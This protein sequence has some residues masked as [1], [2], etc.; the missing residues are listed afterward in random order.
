M[1]RKVDGTALYMEN[2]KFSAFKVIYTYFKDGTL[3]RH[4]HE[5][6]FLREHRITIYRS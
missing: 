4:N 1:G 5:Q 3:L 2:D 6:N